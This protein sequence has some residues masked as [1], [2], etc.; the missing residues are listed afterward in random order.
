TL[1]RSIQSTL[2]APPKSPEEPGSVFG[3]R[4]RVEQVGETRTAETAVG[5][6]LLSK[7][8]DNWRTHTGEMKL[9]KPV[10][11]LLGWEGS[12]ARLGGLI[13]PVLI[14]HGEDDT[15]ILF[16]CAEQIHSA[17][18][19][20]TLTRIVKMDGKGAHLINEV[21]EVAVAMNGVVRGWLDQCIQAG[22]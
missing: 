17:L 16:E 4:A 15:A 13:A 8:V 18:P 9:Q 5:I 7:I 21:A 10:D 19:K 6:E 22:L 1:S 11:V 12:E 14:I 2:G 3:D 20:N